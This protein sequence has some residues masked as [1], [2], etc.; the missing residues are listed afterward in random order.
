M[1]TQ[2]ESSSPIKISNYQLKRNSYS[3]QDEV[4]LNKRTKVE[5]PSQSEINFDITAQE[6]S[7]DL[8]KTTVEQIKESNCNR[9]V[10][11]CGR[12]TFKGNIETITDKNQ[13]IV[14]KQETIF[15]D[16]TGSIRLVLWEK[17][18][19]NVQSR[20][21]YTVTRAIVKTYNGEKYLTLNHTTTIQLSEQTVERED[22]QII[23]SHIKEVECPAEGVESISKYFSCNKCHSTLANTEGK[24]I[25][26]CTNCELSQLKSKTKT[27]TLAKVM[28]LAEGEQLTLNL[29]D[30]KLQQLLEIYK[31]QN[32][33]EKRSFYEL[34][35]EDIV[36]MLLTVEAVLSYN[37]KKSVLTV[38]PVT[39]V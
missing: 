15:T 2:Y 23:V 18:I 33:D 31:T 34:Q 11:V 38:K 7:Q 10:K 12:I 5:I 29:F 32:E 4:H 37:K 39:K 24:K 21:T 17:D 30:D 22:E 36:E 1:K 19:Q 3:N 13:K 8:E 16:S 25:I 9:K 26:K 6:A 28:F 35:D 20:N 27:R 14:L